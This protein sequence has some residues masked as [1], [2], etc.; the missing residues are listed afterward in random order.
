MTFNT[1]NRN[2]VNDYHEFSSAAVSPMKTDQRFN[3]EYY[4]DYSIDPSGD[5]IFEKRWQGVPVACPE[6]ASQPS[7]AG[8]ILM[9]PPP[10]EFRMV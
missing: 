5:A 6:L 2:S 9:A 1:F 10:G 8:Q 7:G 4:D 3:T